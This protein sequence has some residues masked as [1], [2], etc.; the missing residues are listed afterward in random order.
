VQLF[1]PA[2]A[3]LQEAECD[4][5]FV[6]LAEGQPVSEAEGATFLAREREFDSDIWIIELE[7]RNGRHLLDE[8][9]AED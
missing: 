1:G 6:P 7:E 5:R 8:W 4:R 3:G 2:P 9:I